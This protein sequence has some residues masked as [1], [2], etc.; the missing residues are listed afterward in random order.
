MIIPAVK[1][2]KETGDL[3]TQPKSV[4]CSYDGEFAER[5]ARVFASFV[6]GV[7]FVDNGFVEFVFDSSL[8]DKAEIYTVKA[9]EDKIVVRFR[10]LRGAVNG[11]A[12]VA[13]MLRKKELKQCEILDYPTAEYRSFMLDMARGLPTDEDMREAI[14]NM[15]LAKYN[16]LHLHLIDSKGPCYVSRV[17]PEYK[18]IGNSEQCTLEY[19]TELEEYCDFYGIE[20]IPEIEIPAHARA[21][22]DAHPEFKCQVEEAQNWALCSGNEEIY[23]FFEDL[24]TEIAHAFPK[25]KYIHIGTDELEFLDLTPPRVCHWDDCPTCRALREK[26]GLADRQAQFYYMIER[27]N[28]YVKANGKNMMMWNDQ[29]DISKDVPLSRDIVIEFWRIA[30]KGRGPVDG[31]YFNSFLRQGFK[32]INAWYYFTYVDLVYRDAESGMI[33]P[34]SLK[35]W[36][37]LNAPRQDSRYADQVIGAE[38]CAW[39]YG[40]YTSYPYY[41]YTILPS[42]AVY[43]TRFWS[44]EYVDFDSEEY[45][46]ALSE[47]VFGSEEHTDVFECS[48]SALPPRTNFYYTFAKNLSADKVKACIEKLRSNTYRTSADRFIPL[49]EKIL[50]KTADKEQKS[51]LSVLFT[52]G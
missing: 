40:N 22:C 26:E 20:V 5:G 46:K 34:N 2:I 4:T 10:D 36:T 47:F 49:L 30:G 21:L 17:H 8:E 48:G 43:G 25:C 24:I 16:K 7:E 41:A 19:L 28:G 23:P 50:E 51:I 15:A 12:T 31:C 37:P 3:V 6:D 42:I 38:A 35:T 11:A 52:N 1:N 32:V 39:E 33:T 14:W 45:R 13:L 18:Y 29:I 27:I 9:T 44:Y